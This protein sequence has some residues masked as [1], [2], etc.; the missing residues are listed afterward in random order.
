MTAKI[1]RVHE[2]Q[3][4]PIFWKESHST[5]PIKVL[6]KLIWIQKDIIFA[7]KYFQISDKFLK[8]IDC[9]NFFNCGQ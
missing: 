4:W 8:T 2:K 5:Q 1:L 7:L 6:S 9:G 3:L